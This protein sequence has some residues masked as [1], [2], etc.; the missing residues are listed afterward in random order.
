MGALHRSIP[1]CPPPIEMPN[2]GHFVQEWGESVAKAAL[3]KFQ[4]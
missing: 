2:A 4:F 1:N 3:E